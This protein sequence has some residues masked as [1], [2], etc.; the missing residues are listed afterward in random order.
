M[1]RGSQFPRA[2]LSCLCRRQKFWHLRVIPLTSSLLIDLQENV[3]PWVASL[4][5]MG[6]ELEVAKAVW[7]KFQLCAQGIV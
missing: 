2:Q 3:T 6:G 7:I 5:V 1:P 4:E